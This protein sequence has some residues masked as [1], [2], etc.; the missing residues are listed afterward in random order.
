LIVALT[1]LYDACVLYP[2]AI[3]DVL[4]HLAL[5]DIYRARWT[6]A[7]HEE[8]IRS[9]LKNRPDLTRAQLERPRDL[10]NAHAR[11][12]LVQ[13]F[14]DLIPSLSLPDP[15]DRHVLAAAI[16]GRVDA[17]VTYNT[18]DFPAETELKSS[19]RTSF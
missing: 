4:M 9:V 14:E 16:R 18:K 10:M 13:G 1:A 11:D 5:A 19:T 17:I 12:A 3:R 2:A 15:D 7:I 8:W 6:N